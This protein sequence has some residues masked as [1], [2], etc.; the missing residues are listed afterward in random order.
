MKDPEFDKYRQMARGLLADMFPPA[1]AQAAIERGDNPSFTIADG[2]EASHTR[3]WQKSEVAFISQIAQFALGVV[4]MN[5]YPYRRAFRGSVIE[6]VTSDPSAP[7]SIWYRSFI[8]NQMCPAM[9][10]CAEIL[11]ECG[12]ML[13]WPTT[14]E[15]LEKFPFIGKASREMLLFMYHSYH[16]AWTPILKSWRAD[17]FSQMQ[18]HVMFPVGLMFIIEYNMSKSTAACAQPFASLRICFRR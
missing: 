5:K 12:V 17:D 1:E 11:R 3:N 9:Q 10:D 14:A 13:Q 16:E 7:V 4:G 15:L 18:P 6:E 8:E 2:Y